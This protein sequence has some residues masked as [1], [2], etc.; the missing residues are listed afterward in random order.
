[1][2]VLQVCHS[3]PSFIIATIPLLS[4]LRIKHE[5]LKSFCFLQVFLP[6]PLSDGS[7]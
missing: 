4:V 5:Q 3:L 2:N 1:M 7:H 6:C